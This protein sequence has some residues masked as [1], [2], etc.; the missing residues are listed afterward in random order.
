MIKTEKVVEERKR[1]KGNTSIQESRAETQEKKEKCDWVCVCV[2]ES[3]TS[4]FRMRCRTKNGVQVFSWYLLLA[5]RGTKKKKQALKK[6]KCFEGVYISVSF[7]SDDHTLSTNTWNRQNKMRKSIVKQ[8]KKK[9]TKNTF[10]IVEPQKCE[11]QSETR[12]DKR[13]NL[14]LNTCI[15]NWSCL[16]F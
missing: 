6:G 14:H 1:K 4:C 3:V 9:E 12:R 7:N 2:S 8:K 16:P 11:I 5:K 10:R 15:R 13:F